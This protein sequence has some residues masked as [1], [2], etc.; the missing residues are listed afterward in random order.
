LL[1]LLENLNDAEVIWLRFYSTPELGGDM[2]FREIHKNILAPV[3]AVIGSSQ[4]EI[5]KEALQ[6]SYTRATS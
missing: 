3:T 6:S 5:D 1:Q 4:D 2:E